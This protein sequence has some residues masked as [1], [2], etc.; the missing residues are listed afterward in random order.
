MEKINGIGSFSVPSAMGLIPPVATTPVSAP[1]QGTGI[2]SGVGPRAPY[3]GSPLLL[4]CVVKLTV[5]RMGQMQRMNFP[6]GINKG[7]I[8]INFH[9]QPIWLYYPYY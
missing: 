9:S 3:C 2:R 5:N 4:A 8:I 6:K 1:V 7:N